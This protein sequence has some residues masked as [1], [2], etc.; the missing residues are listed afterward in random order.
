M[1]DCCCRCTYR[2]VNLLLLLELEAVHLDGGGGGGGPAVG[3]LRGLTP[4]VFVAL[5]LPKPLDVA[6]LKNGQDQVP[7]STVPLFALVKTSLEKRGDS[8]E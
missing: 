8:G 7:S 3:A 5:P 2:G 1:S 6:K 4:H